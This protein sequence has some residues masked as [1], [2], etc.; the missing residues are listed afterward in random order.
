MNPAYVDILVSFSL[1]ILT[2]SLLLFVSSVFPMLMQ[3][4]RTLLAYEKLANTLDTEVPATLHEFKQLAESVNAL[5]RDTTQKV[6]DVGHKV[7]EVSGSIGLAA[8]E[9]KRKS[10]VWGTALLAGVKSYLSGKDHE[11]K[12]PESRQITTDRGEQNVR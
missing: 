3:A 5:R 6:T 11:D 10:S 2:I 12:L 8:E 1:V 7:E 9:A 4:A